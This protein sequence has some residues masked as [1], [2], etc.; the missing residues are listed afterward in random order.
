ML[1]ER[2]SVERQRERRDNVR[3]TSSKLGRAPSPE[4]RDAVYGRE[5]KD[6][7]GEE[8]GQAKVS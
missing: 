6:W 3:S 1:G 8:A 4:C 7:H 2:G 5:A